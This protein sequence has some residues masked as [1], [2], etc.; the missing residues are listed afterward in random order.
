M[1]KVM[2][3]DDDI[4]L[5]SMY[6]KKFENEGYGVVVAVDGAEVL[7]IAK[8]EKPDIILLDLMMPKVN[9]IDALKQLKSDQ[10]TKMIPVILLTNLSTSDQ[11]E[12]RGLKLGA[13]NYLV[14]ANYTPAEIVEKVGEITKFDKNQP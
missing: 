12:D 10:S 2:L 3:V 6:R 14:K 11:D 5:V 8:T 13:L 1:P 9:G 7:E 4:I